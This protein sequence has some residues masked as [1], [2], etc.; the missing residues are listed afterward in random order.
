MKKCFPF[1]AIILVVGVTS[2]QKDFLNRQPIDQLTET[3]AFVSYD[4]FKSY[5]WGLYDYFASYGGSGSALPTYF[6]SQEANSDNY[7]ISI[8]GSQSAY[9]T[10]TKTIPSAL[11]AA[12]TSMQVAQWNFSFIRRVNVMLDHIDGSSMSQAEKDHWRSVGYF[13]RALR[14]YDMIAAFGDVSWIDHA[15]NINDTT[16]LYAERTP[17]DVVA[18]HVLDD[19][20]WAETH[21]KADGDGVNT[22]NVHVVRALISRFGLFEGTWRKYHGLGDANRYLQACVDASQKLIA[23]FPAVMS[24]YDDVYNSESLKG[25]PGII[26]FKEY[27]SGMMINGSTATTHHTARFITTGHSASIADPTNDMVESYLC[28]DGKSI[29]GSPGYKGDS[30]YSAFRNRDRRLYYTVCPPYRVLILPNPGTTNTYTQPWSY[31]DTTLTP[32]F[33]EFI[34][35]MNNLATQTGRRDKTLPIDSWAPKVNGVGNYIPNIPHLKGFA[36]SLNNRMVNSGTNGASGQAAN[37]LGYKDW[38][39]YNRFTLDVSNGGSNDCPIFRIEEVMLNL[40]EA[41][42]ELGQ[43]TQAIADQT[44]NKLRPRANVANMIVADINAS[45]DAKRD[46]DVDPVLWEIRRERRVEL[47][48][49]G[50]RFNDIKRW[51]KGVYMNKYHLGARLR[52]ADYPSGVTFDASTGTTYRNI[53]F[54]NAPSGWNDKFYLEPIPTSERVINPKLAQSPGW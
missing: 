29:S 14:Y 13:F 39:L 41:T 23:S 18:K 51:K 37:V 2:C 5:S 36:Q 4:N 30:I 21:I 3:T 49:D 40:A 10:G 44:I 47:M 16:E 6:N 25:K 15:L 45:F 35:L 26:L 32:Q 7:Q 12:T 43:F 27:V 24:S 17:R 46:A 54:F 48:G 42:F 1:L 52:V 33:N 28:T 20:L 38:K 19:L 11:G 34:R 22:V 50:F 31:Y 8:S 53:K 9:A